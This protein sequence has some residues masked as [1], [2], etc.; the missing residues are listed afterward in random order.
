[1]DDCWRAVVCFLGGFVALIAVLFEGEVEQLQLESDW[2]TPNFGLY[3]IH[4][5]LLHSGCKFA[6]FT[7]C[8]ELEMTLHSRIVRPHD[9]MRMSRHILREKYYILALYQIMA[10]NSTLLWSIRS[11]QCHMSSSCV[12]YG[13]SYLN[14]SL[15]ELHRSDAPF[16]SLV[17]ICCR[18]QAPL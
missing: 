10:S 13:L 12:V 8:T 6:P 11:T 18:I 4:T 15:P 1:M 17:D 9:F 5:K 2:E 16:V 3:T 7:D 14:C